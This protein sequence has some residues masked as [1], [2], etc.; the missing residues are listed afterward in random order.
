MHS[1][2]RKQDSEHEDPN[3]D[4]D[5]QE[6][7]S[8]QRSWSSF[9]FVHQGPV[10]ISSFF[11]SAALGMS[12]AARSRSRRRRGNAI[13]AAAVGWGP[14]RQREDLVQVGPNSLAGVGHRPGAAQGRA[15]DGLLDRHHQRHAHAVAAASRSAGGARCARIRTRSRTRWSAPSLHRPPTSDPRTTSFWGPPALSSGYASRLRRSATRRTAPSVA[16]A[17]GCG[18]PVRVS[19][20]TRVASQHS[21]PPRGVAPP[22]RRVHVGGRGVGQPLLRDD[23]CPSAPT[24]SRATRTQ[25]RSTILAR[26]ARRPLRGHAIHAGKTK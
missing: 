6:F 5:R 3:E 19:G 26:R 14:A 20:E 12:L 1:W 2:P 11:S 9:C 24:A 25:A 15:G 10:I 18:K 17:P 22:V 8:P 13:S 7:S 21:A 23:F 16:A 4:S